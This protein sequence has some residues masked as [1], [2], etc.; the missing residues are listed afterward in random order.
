[1]KTK[2]I[3]AIAFQEN[4][5]N[6]QDLALQFGHLI[7]WGS[8]LI[9]AA[10]I[11]CHFSL[12][13][14]MFRSTLRIATRTATIATRGLTRPAFVAPR[15]IAA[16][17][18]ASSSTSTAQLVAALRAEQQVEQEALEQEANEAEE[19][20]TF[21][22]NQGFALVEK[23]G[24]DEV[25]LVRTNGDETL[26]IFFSP[27][28]VINSDSVLDDAEGEH[29][30]S[31]EPATTDAEELEFSDDF[32][33]P[34]RLNIIVERAKGALG[35]EAIVQDD[36]VV[37]ESL[38]P[39]PSSTLAVDESA[40]ADY[41]R[42]AIYGGPP[43]SVLDPSVQSSVQEFLESRNVNGDLALFIAEYSSYRENKEYV[44]WLGKIA[45]ILE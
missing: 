11:I 10:K 34:I 1:M 19:F 29:S 14:Q 37:V 30:E 27:S 42:R 16:R 2:K 15:M 24:Q 31:H 6:I 39:Y 7:S 9:K 28:D 41:K 25:Q 8:R 4:Q 17:G 40:E 20:S 23:P 12:F 32:D 21:L 26:R 33:V 3:S 45:D 36:L 43:F 5:P 18:Y 22:Q 44:S 13:T 35:I 38:I